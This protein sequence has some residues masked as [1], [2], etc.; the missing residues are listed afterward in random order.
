MNFREFY[1]INREDYYKIRNWQASTMI[2]IIS[3]EANLHIQRLQEY[4]NTIENPLEFLVKESGLIEQNLMNTKAVPM[5]IKRSLKQLH[6]LKGCDIDNLDDKLLK[7]H[8]IIFLGDSISYKGVSTNSLKK[9]LARLKKKSH[10][11]ISNEYTIFL[12]MNSVA[13]WL[14]QAVQRK[15]WK[16]SVSATD[17]SLLLKQT[18]HSANEQVKLLEEE[19]ET[20]AYD[21]TKPK[22]EIL[23]YLITEF[24][25]YRSRFN[26]HTE[27]YY[28]HALKDDMKDVLY[29]MFLTNS[30]FSL[31]S[32]GQAKA[33]HEAI[34]IQEMSWK[35]VQIHYD[36]FETH[37]IE[38][39]QKNDNYLEI[40]SLIH[41]MVLSNEDYNEFSDCLHDFISQ[42]HNYFLP[43]DIHIQNSR[44]T[45]ERI[46]HKS[47]NRMIDILDSAD[48]SGKILY[49]QTR[50]KQLRHRELE[51]KKFTK[52][53]YFDSEEL[54]FNGLFKEF[55]EIEAEFIRQ[56]K[57]ISPTIPLLTQ[58]VQRQ[59]SQELT[60]DKIFN[61]E[62]RNIIVSLME[63]LGITVNGKSVLTE[64][65]KGALRGLVDALIENNFTVGVSIESLCNVI[66][67][68]IGLQLFSTLDTSKTSELIRKKANSLIKLQNKI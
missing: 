50:L 11:L 37:R 40:M 46:F 10:V 53:K 35:I 13:H 36:I 54:K 30:F 24:E 29:K 12:M 22:S 15:S 42:F 6:F 41:K 2:K 34:L 26:K 20:V 16:E 27:K 55:L 39:N 62:R 38:F 9:P 25:Q 67:R 5:E 23:E 19:I 45:M 33:L 51:W 49:L 68:K 43:M 63:E 17:H 8:F 56:T 48:Q 64:R 4:C 18:V 47:M 14:E 59:I 58:A 44:E 31:D 60:F 28:F 65:K 3:G 61:E 1:N 52:D 57:D 7:E 66:S 32:D 21:R